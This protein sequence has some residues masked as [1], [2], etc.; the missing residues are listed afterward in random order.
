MTALMRS[1]D[2]EIEKNS[3]LVRDAI[4]SQRESKQKKKKKKEKQ[5]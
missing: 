1:T 3:K 5:F 4:E 2:E